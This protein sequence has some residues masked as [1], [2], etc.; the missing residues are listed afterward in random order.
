MRDSKWGFVDKDG[1]LVN[2]QISWKE[3][4]TN[5]NLNKAQEVKKDEFHTQLEDISTNLSTY[6]IE[7]S[8]V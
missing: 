5:K 4:M 6:L 2:V 3:I 7:Q 1:L 8:Y